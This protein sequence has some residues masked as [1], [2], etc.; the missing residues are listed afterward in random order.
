[1]I[2]YEILQQSIENIG[3]SKI[4]LGDQSMIDDLKSIFRKYYQEKIKDQDMSVTHNDPKDRNNL[5]VHNEIVNTIKPYFDQHFE[6]FNFL[7][8]HFVVKRAKSNEAF[9]LHQDWSAVDERYYQNY[10]VWIPLDV[11]YPENGGICFIPESHSFYNNIRSGSMGITHIPI[12]KKMHPYLSYMRLFAGEAAVFHNKTF[13]GSFINSTPKE[14][15]AVLVNITQKNA[16]ALYFHKDDSNPNQIDAFEI[17]TEEIFQHLPK[18]E[19]G[20]L[21]FKKK[22]EFSIEN[23]VTQNSEITASGLIDK[24]HEHNVSKGRAKTYEHKIFHILKSQKIEAK[25]NEKGFVVVDLLDDNTIK[26]LQNKFEETF[27]DTSLFRGT[28]SSLELENAKDRRDLHKFIINTIK[29]NLDNYFKDYKSPVSLLYS[30]K[31]DNQYPLEWHNDPS[32]IFNESIEPLYGIWAP[33]IDVDNNTGAL[34]VIPGSHRIFNKIN[35]A[36]N[37]FKWPL[38]NKRKFLD[39]YGKTF[40]LKAGQAIIFDSRIIHSSEPNQTQVNRNNIVLRV[41]HKYSEYFNVITASNSAD[42]GILYKQREDYFFS[43]THKLHNVKPNTG[44]NVGEI[45]LFYD[46]IDNNYIKEKLEHLT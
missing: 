18:L 1:M 42:K 44:D 5:K 19:K 37:V 43:E 21:P 26:K 36:Y 27:P 3:F 16:Q 15:V 11:S 24:I 12:D 34:K 7:A 20:I 22:A 8:S 17:N 4:Q 39:S 25:I 40:Q 41:H 2:K 13:H 29:N 35:F 28:F 38:E 32:L 10:Q 23:N 6:N 9:Q 30:R 33:F 45:Y 31:A 14:R 46:D